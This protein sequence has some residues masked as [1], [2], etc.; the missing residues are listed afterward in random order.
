M[1]ADLTGDGDLFM[2]KVR[3]DSMIDA[4]IVDGDYVVARAQPT[5]EAGEIVVA[6]HPG[7]GG[8]G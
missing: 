1:P 3:G 7:R 5:A 8:D 6:R 2:L 4:G